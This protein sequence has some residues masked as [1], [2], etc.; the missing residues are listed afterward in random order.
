MLLRKSR[1]IEKFHSLR[2]CSTYIAPGGGRWYLIFCLSRRASSLYPSVFEN[3]SQSSA[4]ALS[5][6][7]LSVSFSHS[8]L[9]HALSAKASRRGKMREWSCSG[10]LTVSLHNAPEMPETRAPA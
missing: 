8:A 1:A 5:L 7:A 10:V 3:R 9:C 4:C 6:T 2:F